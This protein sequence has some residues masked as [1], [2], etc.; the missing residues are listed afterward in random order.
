MIAGPGL[1]AIRDWLVCSFEIENEDAEILLT[2]PFTDILTKE[3]RE[4][5]IEAL[6][7]SSSTSRSVSHLTHPAGDS[8]YP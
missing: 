6:Q 1:S 3:E 5:R 4:R 8:H 2:V 7:A